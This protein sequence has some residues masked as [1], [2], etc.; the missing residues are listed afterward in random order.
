MATYAVVIGTGGKRS[1]GRARVLTSWWAGA[2]PNRRLRQSH[3]PMYARL[4]RNGASQTNRGES[5]LQQM[6]KRCH[7]TADTGS[8]LTSQ[9]SQAHLQQA[10]TQL[11][12]CSFFTR[13]A[14]AFSTMSSCQMQVFDNSVRHTRTLIILR[15]RYRWIPR[16]AANL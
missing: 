11:T 1:Q 8:T 9:Q 2:S 15:H 5:D 7:R 13:G 6:L 12:A 16:E 10:G 3:Q 14:F 4:M